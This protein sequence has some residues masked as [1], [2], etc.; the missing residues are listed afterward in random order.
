MKIGVDF[1]N[2]IARFDPLFRRAALDKHL[3]VAPED[4]SKSQ[5]R[6]RLRRL[7]RENDWTELQGY[8][9]GDLIKEALPFDGVLDFFRTCGE[10][11][12]PVFII[13]HKTKTPFLGPAYDL[14][15]AAR[16]WLARRGFFDAA[17]LTASQ[18][19]LE[20]TKPDK[21]HR[22]AAQGCTHFIDDLP[23]FL[24]EP[25]FP[26]ST[27]GILFDPQ[28]DHASYPRRAASWKELSARLLGGA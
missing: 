8:V 5:I 26:S 27:Q 11:K 12:V 28:G 21:L 25:A 13:S 18:V 10:R 15:Q 6:D 1:D 3:P 4:V 24:G 7:D 9:Y 20:L 23:E 17:G 16:D 14:H 19:F 2:T 22:I